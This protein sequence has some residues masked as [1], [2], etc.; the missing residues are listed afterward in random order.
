MCRSE[1]TIR[2]YIHA[3]ETEGLSALHMRFSPGR[4]S[5]LTSE[6]RDELKQVI[7]NQVPA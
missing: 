4:S 7:V 1:K 5:R 2:S 3:Y 6:Q